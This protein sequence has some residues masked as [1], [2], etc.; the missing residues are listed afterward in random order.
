MDRDYPEAYKKDD[1]ISKYLDEML[2]EISSIV[3]KVKDNV[4]DVYYKEFLKM[5]ADYTEE[6]AWATPEVFDAFIYKHGIAYMTEGHGYTLIA[7]LLSM[8]ASIPHY[9]TGYLEVFAR[10]KKS[11][12]KRGINE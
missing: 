3:N 1:E 6:T 10:I 2:E 4:P 7:N 11:M 9:G 12:L 5:L 8:M